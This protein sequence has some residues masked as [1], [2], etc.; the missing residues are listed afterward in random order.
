MPNIASPGISEAT[1]LR[2]N[3]ETLCV[4]KGVSKAV[5][6]ISETIAP[7]LKGIAIYCLIV[8]LAGSPEVTLWVPPFNVINGGSHA[9]NKLAMQELMILSEGVSTFR[10][11]MRIGAEVYFNLKNVIKEKYGKNAT[12]VGDVGRV[13]PNI[14]E[15]KEALRLLKNAIGKT[16]Y[17]DQ[18]G[19]GMDVA[20]SEFFRFG[21]HDLDFKSPYDSSRY[22][23]PD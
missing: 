22:I 23:T 3:D 19:I 21:K 5:E 6:D 20:A 4:G 13:V 10:E 16:G 11:S 15:N 1:E 8:D 7:A 2:H 14:P 12:N 18:A 9:D 17:L